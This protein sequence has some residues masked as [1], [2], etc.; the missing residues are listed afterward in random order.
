[1]KGD[2]PL[3]LLSIVVALLLTGSL[4]GAATHDN[5]TNVAAEVCLEEP[6]GTFCA[7]TP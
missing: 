2:L 6:V 4:L 5:A 1:M 7:N 3:N